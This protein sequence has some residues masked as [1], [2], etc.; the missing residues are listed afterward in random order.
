MLSVRNNA[1]VNSPRR[2]SIEV[3]NAAEYNNNVVRGFLTVDGSEVRFVSSRGNGDGFGP[4]MTFTTIGYTKPYALRILSNSTNVEVVGNLGIGTSTPTYK[5]H[6]MGDI[7]ISSGSKY[8]INGVNLSASNVG[9]LS[10]TD[11]RISQ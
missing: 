3:V 4:D 6:V 2:N 5:L 9:A 10:S 8:K 7:N 11:S 1:T